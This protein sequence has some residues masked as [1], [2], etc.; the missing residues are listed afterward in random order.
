MT[1]TPFGGRCHTC[2]HDHD[3][4]DARL[5]DLMAIGD[6]ARVQFAGEE[7]AQI[8][9]PLT[10]ERIREVLELGEPAR[11]GGALVSIVRAVESAHGIGGPA[12]PDR[13][14]AA[15][16]NLVAVCRRLDAGDS[17]PTSEQEAAL[18]AAE[19]ALR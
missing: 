12:A 7:P 8:S 15:L 18:A 6:Q 9:A 4:E 17:V 1:L 14:R 16:V 5:R 3:A 10:L 11:E 2:G 13:L 19:E